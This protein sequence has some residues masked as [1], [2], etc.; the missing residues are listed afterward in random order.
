MRDGVD[1][2]IVLLVAPDLTNQESR[3]ENYA[4]DQHDKE[5]DAENQERHFTPVENNPT[6]IQRHGECDKAR[7]QRDEERY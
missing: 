2:R 1:E 6:D 3:I 7:A 5:D 4:E